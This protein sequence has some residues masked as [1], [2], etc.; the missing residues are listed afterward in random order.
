MKSHPDI[1]L[2][3][4]RLD[5]L[6]L[7][8]LKEQCQPMAATAAKNSI[9]HLG[10]LQQLIE[11]EAALRDEHAVARRIGRGAVGPVLRK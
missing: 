4:S 6:R 1:D 9:T 10:Y 5:S 2:F 11:G 8:F 3:N 7:P